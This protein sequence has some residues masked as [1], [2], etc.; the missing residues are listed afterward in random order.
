MVVCSV[1]GLGW[2]KKDGT[3]SQVLTPKDLAGGG[4]VTCSGAIRHHEVQNVE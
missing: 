1:A 3:A 2:A 4:P